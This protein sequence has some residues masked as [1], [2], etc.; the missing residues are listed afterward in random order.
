MALNALTIVALVGLAYA[1]RGQL[2]DTFQKFREVNAP[3]LVFMV[4]F[5]VCNYLAQAKLYQGL[6]RVVGD[7][8]RTKSMIRLALELNFVNTV[9]PSGGVSGFSYIAIRLRDE[10]VSTAKATL[11]QM[12]RFFLIFVSVQLLLFAGLIALAI[13]GQANDFAILIAGVVGTLIVVLTFLGAFIIGSKARINA[14]FTFVT[15]ALNWL[16]HLVRRSHPETISVHRAKRAFT[17]LHEQYMAL[18]TNPQSLK[19]PLLFALISV[20]TEILTI[21]TVYV[22][23][24]SWV[25]IGAVIAAYA[26]AN[27]AG[28]LSILPGGIGIYEALMTAVLTASGVPAALSLSVTVMYRVLNMLIQLPLG[29]FF[30]HRTLHAEPAV[31]HFDHEQ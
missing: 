28:L 20:S 17:E 27:F 30:Y 25:N 8:F 3:V 31:Q 22:A 15:Q 19:K 13:G 23:F 10:G 21:Y 5:Q 6:F 18:R 14:F 16:I 29:Y 4:V 2:A 7:R 9:F 26:V 12:M 11:V 24:G 1:V